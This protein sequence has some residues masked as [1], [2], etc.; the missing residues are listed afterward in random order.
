MDLA[1][2]IDSHQYL[3][4]VRIEEA[5]ENVLRLVVA[6]ARAGGPAH[7]IHI[8]ETLLTGLISIA[9]TEDCAAYEI[10]FESYVAYSV[11]DESFTAWDDYEE[12]SGRLFRVFRK[13]R[14][15][16]YLRTATLAS[17]DHP[18]PLVHYGII[19]LDH[20]VDVAAVDPPEI[21]QLRGI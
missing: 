18:G 8:G 14:F 11:R 5:E 12:S 4:L 7:D 1:K 13:S 19:C 20:I 17:D 6:E 16:D 10:R 15:L 2:K 21:R 3:H 9:T